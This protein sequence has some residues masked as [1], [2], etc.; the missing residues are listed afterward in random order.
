MTISTSDLMAMKMRGESV[1]PFVRNI[2]AARWALEN[3]ITPETMSSLDEKVGEFDMRDKDKDPSEPPMKA[4]WRPPKDLNVYDP[5]ISWAIRRIDSNPKEFGVKKG[6]EGYVEAIKK[7]AKTYKPSQKQ[8]Q[9]V[10]QR[11]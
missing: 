7:L 11:Y 1:E 10:Y 2:Y 5:A 9:Y 6:D 3:G 4:T 8:L